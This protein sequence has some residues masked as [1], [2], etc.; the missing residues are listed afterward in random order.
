MYCDKCHKQSP[1][2]FVTCAYCGATLNLPKKKEPSKFVKKREFRINL[3][4]KK[5]IIALVILASVLVVA[6]IITVS[7]TGSKPEKVVKNFVKATQSA[8]ED[9]YYSLYD[10]NIKK[11][12]KDNRYFGEE[13]T[14]AQIVL[15]M[16]Q[17]DDFYTGKCGESYKLTYKITSSRTLSDEELQRF[18]DILETGFNYVEFPSRVDLLCVEIQAKGETGEYKSVYNDFWCMKIKGRWYKVDKTVYTEFVNNEK[19]TSLN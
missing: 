6:A 13:E 12:K 11:Y 17:S 8:D 4:F 3:S 19:L 9:L 2:N 10:E 5:Q 1:D 18:K 7:F 15:P 16:V 14:Y